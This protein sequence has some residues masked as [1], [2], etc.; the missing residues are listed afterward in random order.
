[1]VGVSGDKR[2]LL[3][4][5]LKGNKVLK[6]AAIGDTKV[7]N[8]RWAGDQHV[9]VDISA[10]AE[11]RPDFEA[12]AELGGVI[13]VNLDQTAPWMIFQK[14][15]TIEHTVMGY[16]GSTTDGEHSYGYFG[17]ITR[18]RARG[19]GDTGYVREHTFSDLYRVDLDSG[20]AELQVKGGEGHDWVT[21]SDGSIVAHSEYSESSGN[22]TLYR[23]P[24]RGTE[25]LKKSTPTD[26]IDLLGLGRNAGEVLVLDR[27]G[28]EDIAES[29]NVTDGRAQRLFE[30]NSV[31]DFTFDPVSQLLLGA[32]TREEPGELLFDSHMQAL[33][34]ITR[35]AFA[36]QQVKLESFTQNLA[37]MIVQTEGT[38]DSGT[39]WYVDTATHRADPIGYAYPKISPDDVGPVRFI[40]YH[41]GDGLA[42]QAVLT[43][44]P[45]REPKSLP[46]VVLPHGGPIGVE[47]RL[48]FDWWAQA[49]ASRGYAVLQPNYRGSSGHGTEFRQA[50]FGQWGKAMLTDISD[51]VAE[52]GRQQ[53]IDPKRVCIMGGSY[54]GYAA[55]AGVTVQQGLYRCAVSVAGPADISSF[56]DWYAKVYGGYHNASYRYWRKEIGADA[57]D[58]DALH[59][60]SPAHFAARADAPI[61][62]I[63]GKDDTRVPIEQS[64]QMAAALKSAGKPYEYVELEKEDHFLSRDATRTAMLKAAVAFVEK[65]NPAQ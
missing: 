51:G 43:L 17:G 23:G 15:D 14:Q 24:Q 41:A 19:F 25:L 42:I 31:L 38:R 12:R 32:R 29:V 52:L 63:H 44:P 45:G 36:A 4:V 56:D 26:D 10:T 53:I 5:E 8:L 34:N 28:A 61:L 55:L 21:S 1:M 27:S 16:Y 54:G 57:A 30:S 11:L 13:N 62:L 47:D 3:V 7:R 48:G 33:F 46:L 60:I 59:D 35:K 20:K 18:E 65:Y 49:L 2:Q 9:L 37:R 6:A 39:Y 22:W 40:D 50:G 64:R 58:Q